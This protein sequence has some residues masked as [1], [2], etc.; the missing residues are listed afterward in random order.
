MTA[1]L[2]DRCPTCGERH[3]LDAPM[4]PSGAT[5]TDLQRDLDEGYAFLS[6]GGGRH[7]TDKGRARLEARP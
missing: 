6:R 7:L 4:P 2:S 5:A 3:D 1:N